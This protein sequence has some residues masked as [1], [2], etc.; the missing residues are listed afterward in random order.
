MKVLILVAALG[1]A[2]YASEQQQAKTILD[3]A[4][5]K[6]GL[7]VHLGCGDGKLTAALRVNDSFLVQG[8]DTNTKNV[9]AARQLV[10]SLGLYGKVSIEQFDGQRLP[11]ADNLVNLIVT[12]DACRV[13]EAEL[14]RVLA[15]NGVA[16]VGGKKTVKPRPKEIDEWTHYLH[17]SSNNAVSHDTVV[18]PPRHMQW[19]GD[20]AWGRHHDHVASLNAMV[21][22]GGRLFA[23]IDEAPTVSILFPPKW[24]LVARDAF[25][26]T[27]L[28]KRPISEW[29]NH[30]WPLKSGPA[31]LPRRLVAV[32]DRV[33]VT[34]GIDAPLTMLDA[35]T[36]ATI[37]TYPETHGT[38]E[39]IFHDGLLFVLTSQAPN[40]WKDYRVESLA[41]G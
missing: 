30:L 5:V 25:N 37:R 26:G 3:T 8:L 4:G 35:A 14:L 18:G 12:S 13:P 7:V 1:L 39:V 15:P 17:D 32:G 9:A 41:S 2:T 40:P 23:I 27:V 6:G 31:Q 21:S 16:L 38:E 11:Y 24:S 29:V 19:V 36:G 10:Q 33:F 22:T 34:L 28:W 20:P